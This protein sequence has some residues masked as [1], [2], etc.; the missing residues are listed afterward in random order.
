M[1]IK[2]ESKSESTAD[3]EKTNEKLPQIRSSNEVEIAAD[4]NMDTFSSSQAQVN[5]SSAV[6]N[7][8]PPNTNGDVSER[9]VGGKTIIRTNST[10]QLNPSKTETKESS[11][12]EQV[13]SQQ[14]RLRREPSINYSVINPYMTR[15]GM[16]QD[17]LKSHPTRSGGPPQH[18]QS[19]QQYQQQTHKQ[20]KKS[21]NEWQASFEMIPGRMQTFLD[22]FTSDSMRTKGRRKIKNNGSY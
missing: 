20:Q 21:N 13:T 8:E 15:N 6:V 19:L 16:R 9:S 22:F 10:S 3:S 1:L 14:P 11:D 4:S 5:S 17:S 12:S 2:L 7:V 18:Q